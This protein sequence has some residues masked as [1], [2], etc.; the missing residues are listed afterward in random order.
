MAELKVRQRTSPAPAQI[1]QLFSLVGE[2]KLLTRVDKRRRAEVGESTAEFDR[3]VARR[4]LVAHTGDRSVRGRATITEAM[5][6]SGAGD[7]SGA[8]A[9]G[10]AGAESVAG[11]GAAAGPPAGP[12]APSG[13]ID[14]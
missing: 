14:G 12:K 10:G 3:I 1:G 6:E 13:T 11:T 5:A 7:E 9:E 8:G 4:N 2:K